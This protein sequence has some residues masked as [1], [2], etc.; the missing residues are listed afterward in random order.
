MSS[1]GRVLGATFTS[2]GLFKN[3]SANALT[4]LGIVADNKIA[5]LSFETFDIIFFILGI[6]PR[7][8]I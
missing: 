4:A 3:S 2:S 7:S 6:K 8:S 1:I 5:C